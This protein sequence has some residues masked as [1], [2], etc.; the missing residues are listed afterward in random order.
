MTIYF[1]HHKG[2][3]ALEDSDDASALISVSGWLD[4]YARNAHLPALVSVGKA[5]NIYAKNAHLPALT[6]VHGLPL[7]NTETAARNLSIVAALALRRGALKMDS[8]HTCDTQHC[9]AGWACF[10]L[11]GGMELEQEFGW[12]TAGIHLLGLDAAKLFHSS[13]R[14]AA[15]FLRQYL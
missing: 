7:P 10:A 15:A 5:L 13:N 6:Q 8:V 14:K 2:N 1:G 12:N 9:M 4:I 11:P 3:I